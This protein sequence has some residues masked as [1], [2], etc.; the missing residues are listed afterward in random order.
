MKNEEFISCFVEIKTLQESRSQSRDTSSQPSLLRLLFRKYPASLLHYT[1]LL[2]LFAVNV[3]FWAEKAIFSDT[4]SSR[5][6]PSNHQKTII[7]TR[8]YFWP[9]YKEPHL[10][11][12]NDHGFCISCLIVR[13]RKFK[14]GSGLRANYIHG[15]LSFPFYDLLSI[16]FSF[17]FT[18]KLQL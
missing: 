12:N 18:Y 9:R 5:N 16:Y 13:V 15:S 14:V 10:L 2:L 4:I 17:L 3:L 1:C 8:S 6:L 11:L 7:A